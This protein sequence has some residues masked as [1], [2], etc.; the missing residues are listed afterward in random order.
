MPILSGTVTFA[1]FRVEPVESFPTDVRRWLSRGLRA[2]A[3]EPI[4]RQTDEER[5]AGFVELEDP[6]ATEFAPGRLFYGEHALLAWRID[7][8]K[9]PA[10]AIKAELAQWAAAFEKEHGRTPA[11]KEKAERRGA[12]RQARRAQAVPVSK[13]FDVSWNLAAQEMQIWAASRKVVDE[14]V[15]AMESSFRIRLHAQVPSV[16]ARRRGVSDGAL[17]PTPELLGIELSG[18]EAAGLALGGKPAK[19]VARGQA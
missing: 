9:V 1:R 2:R 11:R 7:T 15:L 19:E 4:D 6:E 10:A 18:R 17:G 8:L 13:R 5:A 3:F 12:L 14:V 16:I